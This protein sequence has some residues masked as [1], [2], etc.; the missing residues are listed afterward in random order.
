MSP[1]AP[2]VGLPAVNDVSERGGPA[3]APNALPHHPLPSEEPEEKL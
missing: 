2:P 1:V 3:V